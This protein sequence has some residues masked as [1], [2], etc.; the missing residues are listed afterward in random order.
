[1][2][3]VGLTTISYCEGCYPPRFRSIITDGGSTYVV[4]R[5]WVGFGLKVPVRGLDPHIDCFKKWSVSFHGASPTVVKTVLQNG[6]FAI[7]GDKL[8]DGTILASR[9]SAGRRD[10]HFYTSPTASYAGLKLYATLSKWLSSEGQV[11]LM[12]RQD[13]ATLKNTQAETMGFRR[14]GHAEDHLCPHVKLS[15]DIEWLSDSRTG[16]IPYRILVRTF[17]SS[18][19]PTIDSP[20]DR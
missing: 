13:K 10:A 11:V 16:C 8:L 18:N 6:Q 15:G 20:V 17:K 7:P 5:G 3:L 2:A 14:H 9:N 1:M 12:C 4:P 19:R